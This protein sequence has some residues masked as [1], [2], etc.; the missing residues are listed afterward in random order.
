MSDEFAPEDDNETHVQV[1]QS[2]TPHWA[3]VVV[4]EGHGE[5]VET[6]E[7][8]DDH[9]ELLVR[10]DAEDNGLRFPLKQKQKASKTHLLQCRDLDWLN[11]NGVH[12]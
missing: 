10:H 6:D 9:V 5:H 4:V 7:D 8:H 11:L 2:E 1:V 12:S 3:L